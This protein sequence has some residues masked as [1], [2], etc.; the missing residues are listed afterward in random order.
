MPGVQAGREG[1][2]REALY[3]QGLLDDGE[4]EVH[5]ADLENQV[6]NLKTLI[7]SVEADLAS[8]EDALA[9]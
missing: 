7:F 4:L 3:A 5:L 8:R 1:P 9:A 2:L 6:E